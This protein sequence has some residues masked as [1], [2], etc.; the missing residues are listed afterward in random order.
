M[1]RS[2]IFASVAL[3][4][5][6]LL[7]TTGCSTFQQILSGPATGD[8]LIGTSWSGTDSDGDEWGFVFEE[9][10][11][12]QLTFNGQEFDDAT[13]SWNV[14][15]DVITIIITFDNGIATMAGPYIDGDTEIEL[16]GKQDDF[17]WTLTLTQD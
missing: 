1:A 10:K 7:S 16:E 9:D 8:P 2:R 15:D 12:V 3:V 13:D 4:S 5:A 11:T 17:S 6:L 14:A